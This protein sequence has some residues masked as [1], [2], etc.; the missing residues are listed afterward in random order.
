[1]TESEVIEQVGGE[2]GAT[3]RYRLHENKLSVEFFAAEI[4][5]MGSMPGE[6]ARP[7]YR[8]KG[9]DSFPCE[10]ATS[11]ESAERYAEGWVK[12]DGC[13]HVSFGDEDAQLH[14]CGKSEFEKLG[15][16]LCEIYERCGA[17]MKEAGASLL[18]GEFAE[19]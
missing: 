8:Q 9:A 1:M 11:F 4:C 6:E 15:S 17:L 7:E 5:A 2:F 12:W 14:L 13:S 16:I 10:N 18:E 3:V 19:V